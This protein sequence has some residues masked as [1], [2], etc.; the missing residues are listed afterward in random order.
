[1]N[2]KIALILVGLIGFT[3]SCSD[4]EKSSGPDKNISGWCEKQESCYM[5][6]GAEGNI[7]IGKVCDFNQKP[8]SDACSEKFVDVVK[9]AG[10]QSC[11]N[12][13]VLADHLYHIYETKGY[14]P[15]VSGL[16]VCKDEL[17]ALSECEV[18]SEGGGTVCSEGALQ[19]SGNT[20][21][22]C[23]NNAWTTKEECANGCSNNACSEEESPSCSEGALQC[24]GNTLQ[25][26]ANNAWTTKEECANGCSNNACSEE[27]APSCSEGALQ[28]SGNTLQI[29]A[30]KAWMTKEECANGCENKACKTSAG[31][32]NF[33]DCS[34]DDLAFCKGVGGKVCFGIPTGD[35]DFPYDMY[36]HTGETGCTLGTP[37]TYRCME[38]EGEVG[39]IRTYCSTIAGVNYTLIEAGACS[40][41]LCDETT[42]KCTN[43][44]DEDEF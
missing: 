20:L 34:A 23:A 31:N 39:S 8:M 44:Y 25:I 36:C 21:Q 14:T 5:S 30:N 33:V 38:Q 24:S 18:S 32:D 28:C 9:C 2:K 37:D 13:G 22:I 12:Y 3:A 40:G 27:E 1:M 41:N 11:E 26:C 15:N 17:V 19:C 29:C 35:P 4:D 43:G 10:K 6:V 7:F 42:G 16:N